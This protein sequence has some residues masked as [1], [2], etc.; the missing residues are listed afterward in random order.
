MCIRAKDQPPL[1]HKKVEEWKM[2]SKYLI[3][4]KGIKALKGNSS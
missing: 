4:G 1:P 2:S 3:A